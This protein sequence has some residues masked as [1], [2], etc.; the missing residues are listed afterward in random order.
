MDK[1]NVRKLSGVQ[2]A[3][4]DSK[5]R[6]S[7]IALPLP[8]L[9]PD[10]WEISQHPAR[11]KLLSMG[12]RW[13][14]TILGGCL[15]LATAATGG[16][17]GWIVP[18]YR[19]GRPLWRMAEQVMGRAT[20]ANLCRMNRAERTIE[21]KHGG[22]FGIYSADSPDSIRGEAFHLV[23]LDEAARIAED[24]WTDV[25]QPTLADYNGEAIMI[26]TPKGLNWFY[27]E[28]MSADGQR[29]AAWQ[30]PSSANPSPQIQQAARLAQ[31]RVPARTYRQEWLAEFVEDGNYFQNIDACAVITERDRPDEHQGHSI[32]MGV[33][34]GK[35]IDFSVL[36]L[37]C[38]ECSRVVDWETLQ[39]EY[40]HQRARLELLAKEWGVTGILPER[41]SMGAPNIE[42][43]VA[44][45]LPVWA[46]PDRELGWNMTASNKPLLIEALALALERGEI[47][48]P[49]EYGDELRAFEVRTRPQGAPGYGAPEGQHDDRVISLAL[50]WQ[51][52]RQPS[53]AALIA[54]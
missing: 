20:K 42:E 47:R 29:V 8:R 23:I 38:R 30:A 10:Q 40:R 36:T 17:V 16:R 44:S 25:I 37:L 35:T 31:D 24:V 19:N 43:L 2:R 32:I 46:G 28:F 12:R 54:L 41:N 21:F 14:K 48:V 5:S 13:G 3:I 15:S 45:G 22:L 39:G 9:R 4:S 7:I 1:R 49:V 52:A 6:Q 26:S 50:A 18:T 51:A 11:V 33:D 27:R 34:W 53:G